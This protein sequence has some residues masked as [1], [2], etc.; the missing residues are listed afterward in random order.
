MLLLANQIQNFLRMAG[1][2]LKYHEP[3]LII[4]KIQKQIKQ[5]FLTGQVKK[6]FGD[7]LFTF[8]HCILH[9]SLIR[10]LNQSETQQSF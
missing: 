8:S 7:K 2:S 5:D 10:F 9:G 6:Y 1:V 4:Y 3:K